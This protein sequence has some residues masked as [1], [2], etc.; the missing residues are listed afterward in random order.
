MASSKRWLSRWMPAS[1]NALLA[2][3]AL[4]KLLLHLLTNGNYGYFRGKFY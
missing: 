3:L 1:E 2:Y 4:S